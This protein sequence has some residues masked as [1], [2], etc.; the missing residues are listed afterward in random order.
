MILARSFPFNDAKSTMR[1]VSCW[2][3]LSLSFVGMRCGY[4]FCHSNPES[5]QHASLRP[6]SQLSLEETRAFKPEPSRRRWR[7]LCLLRRWWK[8]S[9]PFLHIVSCVLCMYLLITRA[10]FMRVEPGMLCAAPLTSWHARL[11]SRRFNHVT[12]QAWFFF[13]AWLNSWHLQMARCATSWA[14]CLLHTL[15]YFTSLSEGSGRWKA[16]AKRSALEYHTTAVK[17]W[18]L[19]LCFWYCTMHVPTFDSNSYQGT[20]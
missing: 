8:Q 18:L 11:A 4:L 5:Q 19:A 6:I 14:C 20:A 17:P 9:S 1:V 2:S 3:G 10:S 16:A 12:N 13:P 7:R 15:F